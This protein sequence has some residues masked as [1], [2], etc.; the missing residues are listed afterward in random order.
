MSQF[1]LNLL[2]ITGGLPV[3][4]GTSSL[5]AMTNIALETLGLTGPLPAQWADPGAWAKLTNLY[6]SNTSL[7]GDCDCI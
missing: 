3:G 1:M 5:L 4:W 7:T 2:P 6:I